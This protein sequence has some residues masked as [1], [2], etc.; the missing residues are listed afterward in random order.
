MV[1]VGLQL[2]PAPL[3][4][5]LVQWNLTLRGY[6]VLA[7]GNDSYGNGPFRFIAYENPS[8]IIDLKEHTR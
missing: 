8:E 3:S 2:P 6:V 5:S 4:L 7:H 1:T